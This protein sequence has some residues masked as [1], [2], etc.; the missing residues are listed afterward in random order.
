[1]DDDARPP[2]H[3]GDGA[4]M[5][6]C[7]VVCPAAGYG[8]AGGITL[9]HVNGPAAPGGGTLPQPDT[10]PANLCLLPIRMSETLTPLMAATLTGGQG[11]SALSVSIEQPAAAGR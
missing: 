4:A 8:V 7:A 3:S 5:F 1:M 2:A 9:F 6:V 11:S 10:G